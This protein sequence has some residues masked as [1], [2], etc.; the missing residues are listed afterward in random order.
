MTAVVVGFEGA[1]PA[2]VGVAWGVAA[3]Q[4]LTEDGHPRV[5]NSVTGQRIPLS[6]FKI[7][8][9]AGALSRTA[10]LR[11]DGHDGP[12]MVVAVR[13]TYVAKDLFLNDATC[14]ARGA[15]KEAYFRAYAYPS[16]FD[17]YAQRVAEDAV[18]EFL[19]DAEVR[20]EAAGVL[21][22]VSVL[23]P[24]DPF[25]HVAR[26]YH[27]LATR[28]QA[29]DLTAELA[30]EDVNKLRTYTQLSQTLEGRG[31]PYEIR[32][33]GGFAHGG[34]MD[35]D[36]SATQFSALKKMHR[37]LEPVVRRRFGF[38]ESDTAAPAPRVREMRPGSAII[39]FDAFVKG[40]PPISTLYR[41]FELEM[42]NDA[43]R[44]KLHSD[45]S[46]DPDF[47]DG[48]QTLLAPTEDT[49][50]QVRSVGTANDDAWEDVEY[51][52]I[53]RQNM[54]ADSEMLCFAVVQGVVSDARRIELKL[55]PR[56]RHIVSTT[57]NGSGELPLGAGSVA[58]FR[59][60]LFEP[61]VVRLVRFSNAAGRERFYVR[62]LQMLRSQ[63]HTASFDMIPS[64]LIPGAFVRIDRT[65]AKRTPEGSIVLGQSVVGT[66]AN[67][68]SHDLVADWLRRFAGWSVTQELAA[69]PD[70]PDDWIRPLRPRETAV[71]RV[72]DVLEGRR[73]VDFEELLRDL[74][75]EYGTRVRRSNTRRVLVDNSRFVRLEDLDD[76]T[77]VELTD[78]GRAAARI[79][80]SF[81]TASGSSPGA[82]RRP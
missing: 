35:V 62:E 48:L 68:A 52:R 28:K 82:I 4:Q 10:R 81:R 33:H 18:A 39:S 44:G 19:R 69:S 15:T 72:L 77:V 50:V 79:R 43:V 23:R 75:E 76:R 65:T 45:L 14:R 16:E 59:E 61:A 71:G 9:K 78:D 22:T 38:L 8:R 41:Y 37:S 74:Q 70:S 13:R 63:A 49:Q 73:E 46:S 51:D 36:R 57:D 53:E 3:I 24:G 21:R 67:S 7:L 66:G 12:T 11:L 80:R 64:A 58:A 40:E 17:A 2:S 25:V 20:D 54:S 5:M 34:G 29:V 27:S 6:E 55:S 30:L 26:R 42:I 31:R 47:V 32:Y 56:L 60:N 1:W